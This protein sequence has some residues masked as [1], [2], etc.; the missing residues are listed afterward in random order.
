MSETTEKRCHWNGERRVLVTHERDCGTAGCEGCE[1]CRRDHCLMPRCSRHLR[2]HEPYVCDHCVGEVRTKLARIRDL[3]TLAPVA[4]SEG[5]TESRVAVLVGPVPE[6]STH[7]A[8][9]AWA[10]RGGL[11]RCPNC[12]D[13]RPEPEGPWC[14]DWKT[15]AHYAC[16][17]RTGRATCPDLLAWLDQADDER[18]PLWVLGSWDMLVAE[19]FGHTRTM[20]VTVDSAAAYLGANLTDLA[21]HEDFAFDEL[22]RE[23]DD[24]ATHVEDVLSV[25]TYV[26]RGAPC[27]ACRDAGRKAKPLERQYHE[28]V[29][30]DRD[31]WTCPICD[32]TFTLDEYSK[33][34]YV[35]YL[36][37]ADRLTAQQ[38]LAQYRVP[39]G[40]LRR[41]ANG[42]TDSRGRWHEPIVRK[43]GYDGQRRQLYDV[44]DVQAARATP[45][46]S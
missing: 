32:A 30:D 29:T 45:Q 24:C 27:P 44:S 21:R 20:R 15:C 6:R 25:G 41:W 16:R 33:R 26:Q 8:R 7:D 39:E 38:M 22:A 14:E 40:T 17:R 2:D 46:A 19:H 3:C 36:G 4:L 13:L 18:H 10:L 28:G 5:G 34:V 12:P 1:P 42:W 23:I 37:E 9:R 11:C 31:E 43:R 35:D